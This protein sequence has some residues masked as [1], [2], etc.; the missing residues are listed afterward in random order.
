M[1]QQHDL[2]LMKLVDGFSSLSCFADKVRTI[3][4]PSLLPLFVARYVLLPCQQERFRHLQRALLFALLFFH[5]C[6]Q[7]FPSILSAAKL[8]LMLVCFDILMFRAIFHFETQRHSACE[9]M[10]TNGT[11]LM[12]DR[13][14]SN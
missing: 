5:N 7:R 9:H 6:R 10:A 8:C 11:W 12:V 14:W 4:N 1:P 2:L 3:C 13:N